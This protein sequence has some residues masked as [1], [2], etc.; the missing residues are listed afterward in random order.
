MINCRDL[1][2]STELSQQRID[3]AEQVFSVRV[4]ERFICFSMYL[5]GGN[6]TMISEVTELPHGSV[7]SIIR[8]LQRDGLSAFEDRRQRTSSFLPPP[9]PKV[10]P[11]RLYAEGEYVVVDLGIPGGL[12]KIPRQNN[13]QIRTVILSLLNSGL[14]SKKT[15]ATFLGLTPVHTQNLAQKLQEED[16]SALIDKRKGQQKDYRFTPEIKA[17]LI[18]QFVL[19][20]VSQGK[21][22]GKQL[23][24]GLQKRCQFILPERSIRQ[25]VQKLGLEAIKQSLPELLAEAKKNSGT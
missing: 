24:Q 17:E 10:P 12:L 6:R 9:Q 16:I 2:F 21:T 15:V 19:D 4:I 13:L 14:L 23:S 11:L 3:R 22:T 1:V 7:R 8:A 18:Q 5:L 25:H 20:I